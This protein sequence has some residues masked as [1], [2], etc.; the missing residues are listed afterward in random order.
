LAAQKSVNQPFHDQAYEPSTASKGLSLCGQAVFDLLQGCAVFGAI[1]TGSVNLASATAMRICSNVMYTALFASG[2]I[3]PNDLPRFGTQNERD[4]RYRCDRCQCP[5]HHATTH[6]ADKD[7]QFSRRVMW[8]QL[9]VSGGP[10]I[11][12]AVDKILDAVLLG[13]APRA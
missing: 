12:R 5:L 6:I 13:I 1:T 9:A 10:R 8:D 4:Q 2:G 7:I 3:L 11:N